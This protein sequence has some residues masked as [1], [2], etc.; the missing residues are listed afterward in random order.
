MFSKELL[1]F[2]GGGGGSRQVR[3]TITERIFE[4]LNG[5]RWC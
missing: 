4:A 3:H 2:L 5:V 1:E